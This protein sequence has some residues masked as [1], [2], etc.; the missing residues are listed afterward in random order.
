M[1]DFRGNGDIV[2]VTETRWGGINILWCMVGYNKRRIDDDWFLSR[3][4]I[5]RLQYNLCRT[6]Q[7]AKLIKPHTTNV[8][9]RLNVNIL[10]FEIRFAW[11]SGAIC[12]AHRSLVNRTTSYSWLYRCETGTV[13]QEVRR[14]RASIT[15]PALSKMQ[16]AFAAV[17]RAPVI[18]SFD[19]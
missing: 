10:L 6:R 1:I 19:R 17:R 9:K 18:K 11:C 8:S 13:G 4:T 12:G 2:V 5:H 16:C 3:D 15:V 14:Y 7:W